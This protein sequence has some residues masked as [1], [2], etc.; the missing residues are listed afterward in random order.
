[1]VITNSNIYNYCIISTHTTIQCCGKIL[2][3]IMH[4][5]FVLLFN[6]YRK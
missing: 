4:Y 5:T 6:F 3:K 2:L 1:M